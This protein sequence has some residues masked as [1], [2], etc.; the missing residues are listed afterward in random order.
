MSQLQNDPIRVIPKRVIQL[1]FLFTF[2]IAVVSMIFNMPMINV[3]IGYWVGVIANLI[4]FRLIVVGAKNALDQQE[5]GVRKT[6]QMNL[7]VR[8]IIYAG[9]LVSIVLLL[10]TEAFIAG[11][12]GVSMGRFA[13]QTDGFFTFGYGKNGK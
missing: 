2:L 1:A 5:S 9:T 7:L 6:M 13:I 12:I 4:N 8:L 3:L 10:G 11:I